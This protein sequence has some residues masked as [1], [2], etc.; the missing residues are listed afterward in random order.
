MNQVIDA[1]GNVAAHTVEVITPEIVDAAVARNNTPIVINRGDPRNEPLPPWMIQILKRQ[2]R[3]SRRY[4]KARAKAIEAYNLLIDDL[5][6]I[7]AEAGTDF[8]VKKFAEEF[9]G[10]FGY[11]PDEVV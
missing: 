6:T 8:S 3:L 1:T 7:N 5:D 10:G 2:F 4:K 9:D 11:D